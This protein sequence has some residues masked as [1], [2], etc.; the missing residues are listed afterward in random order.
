MRICLQVCPTRCACLCAAR[1]I[2]IFTCRKHKFID[3]TPGPE[4]GNALMVL[5]CVHVCWQRYGHG[6][7]T[8]SRA[9]CW[10]IR[11]FV[12]VRACAGAWCV[13]LGPMLWGLAKRLSS[14]ACGRR[15]QGKSPLLKS[16]SLDS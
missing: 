1:G 15:Q 14:R 7:R 3:S 2:D 12:E 4:P 10:M 8:R 9:Q 5:V 16:P 13:L 6:D 11:R